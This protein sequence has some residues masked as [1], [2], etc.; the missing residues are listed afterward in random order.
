MHSAQHG[1]AVLLLGGWLL[2]RPELM[3]GP[4]GPRTLVDEKAPV[5]HWHHSGVYDTAAGCE[6]S[7]VAR[8][9]FGNRKAASCTKDTLEGRQC[10]ASTAAYTLSRCVPA[11]H[12]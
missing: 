5:A 2:M 12:F 1:R 6:T 7:L 10:L 3:D 9:R 11:E 4:Q 8:V